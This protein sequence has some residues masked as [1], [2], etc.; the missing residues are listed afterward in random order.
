[1]LEGVT[2]AKLSRNV[3]KKEQIEVQAFPGA[4]TNCLK[5]HI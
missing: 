3:E 1:M 2:G 4:T 5:H